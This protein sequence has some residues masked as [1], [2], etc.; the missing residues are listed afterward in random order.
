MAPGITIL[1]RGGDIRSSVPWTPG[2]IDPGLLCS[3][4][5]W[6][7]GACIE[8]TGGSPSFR[9]PRSSF[10]LGGGGQNAGLPEFH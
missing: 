2:S 4:D 3:I 1:L 9:P 10:G 5:P 7:S 8:Q 6:D